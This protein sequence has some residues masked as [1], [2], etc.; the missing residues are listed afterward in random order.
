MISTIPNLETSSSRNYVMEES[1]YGINK[2]ELLKV[3][4]RY[5]L[6]DCYCRGVNRTTFLA[7]NIAFTINT[8]D[9]DL[10]GTVDSEWTMNIFS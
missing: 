5:H 6:L 9:P 4:S 8:E 7:L 10:G 3:G 1:S 2:M